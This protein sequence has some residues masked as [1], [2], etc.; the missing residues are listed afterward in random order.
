MILIKLKN[1][2]VYENDEALGLNL[3]KVGIGD[4]LTEG[5]E[6]RLTFK[7]PESLFGIDWIK[8]NREEVL[9]IIEV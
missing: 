3:D 2:L 5:G 8:I 1:G 7:K 6:Y 4:C 9:E